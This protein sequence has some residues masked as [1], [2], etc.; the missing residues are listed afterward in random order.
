M[1]KTIQ[2]YQGQEFQT[3]S[4]TSSVITKLNLRNMQIEQEKRLADQSLPRKEEESK[5]GSL[6]EEVKRIQF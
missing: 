5:G 6:N 1:Y 4:E 2:E 3:G